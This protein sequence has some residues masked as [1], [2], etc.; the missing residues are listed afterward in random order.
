MN[1]N[2]TCT[3]ETESIKSI[4]KNLIE[5]QISS[6]INERDTINENPI[7]A[8]FMQIINKLIGKKILFFDLET[9]GLPLFDGDRSMPDEYPNYTNNDKYNTARILQI[10]WY[11]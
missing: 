9:T 5:H 6:E 7:N 8:S 10:G 1:K 11:Y 4:D 3:S 2:D